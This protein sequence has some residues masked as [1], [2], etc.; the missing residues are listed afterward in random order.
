MGRGPFGTVSPFWRFARH[1]V[2]LAYPDSPSEWYSHVAWANIY[3]VSP[4]TTLSATHRASC[5]P[6]RH[7]LQQG[8]SAPSPANFSLDLVVVVGGVLL[9]GR[10]RA[11]AIYTTAT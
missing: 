11:T 9:V 8:S 5:G 10:A 2:E 6:G 7:S 1:L 3:P 4:A